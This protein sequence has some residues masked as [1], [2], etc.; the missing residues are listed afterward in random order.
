MGCIYHDFKGKCTLSDEMD[1]GSENG[2]CVCDD[3][4]DPSYSCGDYESDYY[5]HDC[6]VDL[7]V[8]EC[9]CNE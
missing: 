9:K 1:N 2:Y 4:P 8:K 5:C 6:G 3:D 7:N